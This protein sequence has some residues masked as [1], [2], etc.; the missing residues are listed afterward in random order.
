MI[1]DPFQ[2]CLGDDIVQHV[3]QNNVQTR[4]DNATQSQ[5]H[6]HQRWSEHVEVDKIVAT[7][8]DLDL[9]GRDEDLHDAEPIDLKTTQN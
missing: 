9:A 2:G 5:Q 8:M 7:K 4:D 3:A 6:T 1:S